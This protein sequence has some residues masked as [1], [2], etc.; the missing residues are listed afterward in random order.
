MPVTAHDVKFTVDLFTNPDVVTQTANNGFYLIDSATVLDDSTI[1]MTYKPGS[2]WHMYWTPGYW[3]VFY[4]KHLLED[5]DPAEINEWEFWRRPVGNG[6][7]RYVRHVP[8][9]MMEFEANPDFYLGK[10]QIDH[11]LLKFGGELMADLQAG[12]VDAI[13][14]ENPIAVQLLK[15]DPRFDIYYESWDDI[16][17]MLS[18]IWNHRNPL[19]ADARVRR[20]MAHAIDRH[21]LLNILDMWEALPVV[22]VPFTEPQYWNDQLPEPLPYDPVLARRLLDEAGWHDTDGNGTRERN[23]AE[24]RFPLIVSQRYQSIAVY[25]QHMLQEVGVAVE[26]TT[27]DGGAVWERTYESGAFAVSL[28]YVWISPDDPDMGLEVMM[29]ENSKIGFHN[30]RAIELVNA[31]MGA[32]NPVTLDSIYRELAPIV[33][34]E[35]PFTFLVFGVEAYAV[36]RRVKGLSSPFRANPLWAAGHLRIEEEN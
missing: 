21:E 10:P 30:P 27:L 17:T 1:V 23:G 2:T 4:P 36:Q 9:T 14:L 26:I 3:Q 19:F 34:E 35:Q 22:D 31:A 16:S 11:V 24:F 32:T 18:L 33:Q 25:V 7:F 28:Y 12:N 5:L 13:N 6:P 8:K 15:D 29:G 20:A